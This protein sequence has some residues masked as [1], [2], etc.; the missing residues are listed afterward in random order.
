MGRDP[1]GYRREFLDLVRKAQAA[2]RARRPT[3]RR[4]EHDVV[5]VRAG[6]VSLED[7]AGPLAFLS[8]SL[9]S[10]HRQSD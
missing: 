1:S 5:H 4:I 10:R 6:S 7:A 8:R 3:R 2:A 9:G